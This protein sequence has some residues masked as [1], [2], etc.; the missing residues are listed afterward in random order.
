MGTEKKAG[1]SEEVQVLEG[2]PEAEEIDRRVEELMAPEPEGNGKK[3][4]KKHK[5]GNRASEG[6]FHPVRRFKGFSRKRKIITVLILAA[7]VL[8][9]FSRMSGE[10]RRWE[11]RLP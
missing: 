4:K 8:F 5:A 11:F 2:V 1:D 3:K 10:R 6:G 9:G 7:V